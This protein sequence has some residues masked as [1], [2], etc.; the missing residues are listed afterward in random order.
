MEVDLKNFSSALFLLRHL[1]PFAKVCLSSQRKYQFFS[2]RW[3]IWIKNGLLQ[4][5]SKPDQLIYLAALLKSICL[6]VARENHIPLIL[7]CLISVLPPLDS[8]H[9]GHEVSSGAPVQSCPSILSSPRCQGM[10]N[11]QASD[12]DLSQAQAQVPCTSLWEL[13]EL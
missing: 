4:L 12:V 6:T 1:L 10:F 11:Q 5:S 2:A 7:N 3:S 8:S 9:H 13:T